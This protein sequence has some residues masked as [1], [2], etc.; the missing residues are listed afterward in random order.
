MKPCNGEFIIKAMMVHGTWTII[1]ILQIP[2]Q[3][4]LGL[5]WDE[6]NYSCVYDSLFTILYHIWIEGQLKHREYFESGTQ[7]LKIIHLHTLLLDNTCTFKSICDQ[8]G[9]MLNHEKPSQYRFG[10]N[11]TDIDEL[12]RILP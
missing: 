7:W 2:G 11:Y 10:K 3:S 1:K 4:P 9:S 6:N 5:T 12:V 8:L